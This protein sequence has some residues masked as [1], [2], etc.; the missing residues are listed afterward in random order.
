MNLTAGQL[1]HA[2]WGED[3][4]LVGGGNIPS[5]AHTWLIYQQIKYNSNIN[6]F[7]RIQK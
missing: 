3:G 1:L 4:S 6:I 5:L 2:G 7:A